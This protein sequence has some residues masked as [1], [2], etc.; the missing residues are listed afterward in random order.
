MPE[1][2]PLAVSRAAL[3]AYVEKDRAAIERLVADDFHFTSPMDNRI[4]RTT[5][6]KIC[7]PNSEQMEAV[8]ILASAEKGNQAFVVYEIRTKSGKRFRNSEM[9]TAR[10]GK[11]VEAH[12]FFGWDVPHPAPEG[13]HKG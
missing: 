13:K 5:Y 2:N 4:D 9:H 7:W 8:D 10:D 1:T 11:L 3:Q 6:M 12:V